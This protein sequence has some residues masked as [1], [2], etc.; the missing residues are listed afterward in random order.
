MISLCCYYGLVLIILANPAEG[1]TRPPALLP[2]S[3]DTN[4][5]I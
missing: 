2:F 1:Y 5:Q 3:G 4:Q